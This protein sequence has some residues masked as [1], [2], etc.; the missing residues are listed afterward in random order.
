MNQCYGSDNIRFETFVVIQNI[1]LQIS[2]I[3]LERLLAFTT[4]DRHL[5]CINDLPCSVHI[6]LWSFESVIKIFALVRGLETNG[7]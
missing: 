6:R 1:Q 7:D 2:L 5:S 4:I 3:I